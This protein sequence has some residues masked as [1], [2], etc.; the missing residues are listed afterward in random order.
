MGLVPQVFDESV[1]NTLRGHITVGH[2]RY[3]TSGVLGL[4]ERPAHL[5][6]YPYHEP[7]P[8]PQRQPDQHPRAGRPGRGPGRR[9]G[10]GH[11][12]HRRADRAVRRAAAAAG[13]A[14]GD[15]GRRG[16]AQRWGP[17]GPGRP[18]ALRRRDGAGP[19]PGQGVAPGDGAAAGDEMVPRPES[20]VEQAALATLPLV[21]GAFSLVFMD[22]RTLYAARDPQGFRPLVIGR[23]AARLGGRQRDRGAGHRRGGLRPRGRAGRADRHRRAGPA[24]PRRSRP[25]S[26]AAAC[27]ST[28]TW[29]ARIPRSPAAACR[30]PGSRS[31]SGWP[32]ST[33]PRRTW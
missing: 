12:R 3:S 6:R 32:P 25:R 20:G 31:A 19:V 26:R 8:G 15:A 21:R 10:P 17:A 9:A 5:P 13:H 27:S 22:E 24:V 33:R 16:R 7:G 1:L 23:L 11:L 2:C 29:P 4:G 30:P 28:S 18:P 14:A